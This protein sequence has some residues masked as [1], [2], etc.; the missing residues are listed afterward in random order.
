M[1]A[2][3]MVWPE[4]IPAHGLAAIPKAVEAVI[5]LGGIAMLLV[6]HNERRALL[7]ERF[8]RFGHEELQR[9]RAPVAVMNREPIFP[10]PAE[11]HPIPTRSRHT[12]RV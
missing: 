2:G 4:K 7:D 5:P 8:E 10:E 3:E 12:D 6:L 11:L 9:H 1:L